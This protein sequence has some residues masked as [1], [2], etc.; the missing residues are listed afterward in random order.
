MSD[1]FAQKYDAEM[2]KAIV[3]PK[4]YDTGE[5][6]AMLVDQLKNLHAQ[7]EGAKKSGKKGKKKRQKE[8]EEEGEEEG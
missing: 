4:V 7:L 5:V 8:G 1:N 3:R 6:D 2:T